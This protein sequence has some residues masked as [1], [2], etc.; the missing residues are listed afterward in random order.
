M[1]SDTKMCGTCPWPLD[2]PE[3]SAPKP[4]PIAVDCPRSHAV[5]E[6]RMGD[7][8]LVVMTSTSIATEEIKE[9]VLV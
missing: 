3:D 2:C 5:W 4:D 8:K 9:E 7:D 1:T 6:R